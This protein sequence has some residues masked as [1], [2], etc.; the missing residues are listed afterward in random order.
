MDT[1]ITNFTAKENLIS[2]LFEGDIDLVKEYLDDPSN[3]INM[4]LNADGETLLIIA[5]KFRKSS[6]VKFLISKHADLDKADFKGNTALHKVVNIDRNSNLLFSSVEEVSGPEICKILLEAGANKNAINLLG[7]TPL[8]LAAKFANPI[9]SENIDE[10]NQIVQILCDEKVDLD[11]LDKTSSSALIWSAANNNKENFHK[12]LYSGCN[13]YRDLES[14][15]KKIN[16]NIGKVSRIDRVNQYSEIF[17]LVVVFL[18]YERIQILKDLSE[19]LEFIKN[20]TSAQAEILSYINIL[21][22]INARFEDTFKYIVVSSAIL[23]TVD[24]ITIHPIDNIPKVLNTA[25]YLISRIGDDNAQEIFNNREFSNN[26]KLLR[27]K[28]KI[29]R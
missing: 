16:F 13:V 19:I 22:D 18:R 17:K 20:G 12:L 8:I 14:A 23:R 25:K 24:F 29:D 21:T 28:I 6:I 5:T 15:L 10:Y 3:D 1:K 7:E 9:N 2:A 11:I 27:P 26:Q 4:R